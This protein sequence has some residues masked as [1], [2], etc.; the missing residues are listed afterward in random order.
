VGSNVG[1]E[2]GVI[3]GIAVGISVFVGEIV[4]NLVSVGDG[5][6]ER[7]VSGVELENKMG[8]S[9]NFGMI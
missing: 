2:V 4:G 3:V 1:K 7:V 6:L 8:C 5:V 9:V